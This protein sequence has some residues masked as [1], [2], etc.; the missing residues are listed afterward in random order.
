MLA[1]SG[2][3][4]GKRAI[5]D[6]LLLAEEDD[7][8]GELDFGEDPWALLSRAPIEVPGGGELQITIRDM[9]S[10][11]NLNGLLDSEGNG[12]S[13]SQRFLRGLVEK[14]VDDLPGRQEEKFYEPKDIAD[15]ILDWIDTDE[16]TGMGDEESGYYER[17]GS[18]G[19]PPNRPLFDLEELAGIPTMDRLLLEGLR[20]YFTTYPLF[21]SPE[22][23]G[24]NPNTAP[25][26]LLAVLY[27]PTEER[28]LD[29]DDVFRILRARDEGRVFCP[30]DEVD[31]CVTLSSEVDAIGVGTPPF[32]PLQF[33]SNVFVIEAEGRFGVA[34]ARRVVVLDRSDPAELQILE[35]RWE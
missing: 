17:L 15:A 4:I 20:A 23:I 13:D 26:H 33:R 1:E 7:P 34:R 3:E 8:L 22:S 29:E 19:Q 24:V 31:P 18:T 35:Y 16:T 14:V 12:L 27:N 5:L 2:V 21:P 28:F 25:P 9:G 10:R 11:I 32:P 6:D 30:S